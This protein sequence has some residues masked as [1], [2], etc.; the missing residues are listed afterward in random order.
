MSNQ[1]D[2]VAFISYRHKPLDKALA[3]ALH[4]LLE[5]YVIPA[6]YR[7]SPKEKHLGIV[8]RDRDEL[9]L[10][11]HLNQDIYTALDHS[12]YLI[13]ICTQDTPHS[14]WVRRE[15]EYFIQ[16]HGRD[17][18]L[19]VLAQ[20]PPELCFP[21]QLTKIYSSDDTTAPEAME[22]LAAY[23][24]GKN[25]LHSLFLLT[26]EF[27]RLVAAI[28]QIPYGQLMQRHKRRR[29]RQIIMGLSALT[30]IAFGF[31]GMLLNRNAEITKRNQQ[32]SQQN[33]QILQQSEEIQEKNRQ[34]E[35]QLQLTL[36][37]ESQSLAQLS[38]QQ[39]EDGDRTGAL[40]SALQ[41]LPSAERSRPY[42]PAA[43]HALN[44]ALYSY[45]PKALRYDITVQQPTNIYRMALS[46]DGQYVVTM[47]EL[48]RLRCFELQHGSQIWEY[49]LAGSK[50][51]W[52]YDVHEAEFCSVQI[53]GSQIYFSDQDHT[54]LLDLT[55][56][57]FIRSID[58]SIYDIRGL[59]I[60][61]NGSL[62]LIHWDNRKND[63]IHR[64]FYFYDLNSGKK[65][66]EISYSGPTSW[67][68][69]DFVISPDNSRL[70]LVFSNESALRC[71]VSSV[72]IASGQTIYDEFF[73]LHL[74][75]A[76]FT[77]ADKMALTVLPDLR[78]VLYY[79]Q[80]SEFPEDLEIYMANMNMEAHVRIFSP[81]GQQLSHLMQEVQG[82]YGTSPYNVSAN[83]H[84]IVYGLDDHLVTLYL[85]TLELHDIP[86]HNSSDILNV[87]CSGSHGIYILEDGSIHITDYFQP[88]TASL[89]PDL[90]KDL[91]QAA[92]I[93][94][95]QEI[96]AVIAAE[97]PHQ[98]SFLRMI[99][100]QQITPIE[101][102]VIDSKYPRYQVCGFPSGERFVILDQQLIGLYYKYTVSIYDSSSLKK[103]GE[104]TFSLSEAIALDL[105][106]FSADESKLIFRD[107]AFD[108]NT[109]E[110]IRKYTDDPAHTVILLDDY[111]PYDLDIKISDTIE[112]V[113]AQRMCLLN[114][115]TAL[116]IQHD[117]CHFTIADPVNGT[118]LAQ[119]SL[120]NTAFSEYEDYVFTLDPNRN[121][122]YL[123]N[124]YGEVTG[125][126]ISTETWD[127]MAQIP[128]LICPIPGG[129]RILCT[130]RDQRT[131][132]AYPL[133]SLEELVAQGNQILSPAP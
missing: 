99:W 81:T 112:K 1:R 129:Q 126:C 87:Y 119:Y 55:N 73:D 14:E 107:H 88:A 130:D 76:Y 61:D 113:S 33:E 20:D 97:T 103:T 4:K 84:C 75:G 13:V 30:A 24:A 105:S 41:A 100:D 93:G 92:G 10:S 47:D 70:F 72:D 19:T 7:K 89:Y 71:Q 18:V 109:Q 85:D 57:S 44:H 79:S 94:G 82:V 63:Q 122:L 23:V 15:I 74:H 51:T 86:I 58:H 25:T 102:A 32:I 60:S 6:E 16:K 96:L 52:K 111:D 124:R 90:S 36:K 42:V 49:Q 17:R 106:G 2:Y 104:Y 40:V 67:E 118:V 121:T 120:D 5:H 22:P 68:L 12:Q 26:K 108:L 54:I 77:L 11:S 43:E 37:N 131:I 48:G 127:V 95:D 110:V 3:T 132:H 78:A 27:K 50:V 114:N 66:Q 21:E 83:D 65:I 117:T 29:Q 115:N 98:I 28:L 8:F 31:V 53:R 91:V 125:L 46:E 34:I 116:L 69:N 64:F 38:L 62:L 101:E 59:Q 80:D 39:L 9:P 133:Y 56:G 128:N 123:Y 45:Q 35:E